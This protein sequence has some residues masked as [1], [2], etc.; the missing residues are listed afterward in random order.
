MY[1]YVYIHTHTHV[2]RTPD[3][4]WLMR[5]PFHILWCVFYSRMTWLS[6]LFTPSGP[7]CGTGSQQLLLQGS[8]QCWREEL[9]GRAA[10]SCAATELPADLGLLLH[11]TPQ[12]ECWRS[13]P[14]HVHCRL[15]PDST[16]HGERHRVFPQGNWNSNYCLM[17]RVKEGNILTLTFLSPWWKKASEF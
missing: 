4:L 15:P 5:F 10:P 17:F 9:S 13:V 1:E 14:P 3:Q 11:G 7:P 16:D 12:H 2:V 6:L 8:V